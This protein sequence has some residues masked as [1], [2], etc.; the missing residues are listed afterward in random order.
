MTPKVC[1]E[2]GHWNGAHSLGCPEAPDDEMLAALAERLDEEPDEEPDE[3][4]EE[5]E[6]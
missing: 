5:D 3:P 4:T 1:P 6:P 2:C